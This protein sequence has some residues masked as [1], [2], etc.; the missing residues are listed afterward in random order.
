MMLVQTVVRLVLRAPVVAAVAGN[1]A[2]MVFYPFLNIAIMVLYYDQRVRK[3]GYD[4]D[5]MTS[6]IPASAAPR[7]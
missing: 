3:E 1:L 7:S 4:L 5:V 6:A 2:A